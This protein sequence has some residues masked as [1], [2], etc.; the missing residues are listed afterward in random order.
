MEDFFNNGAFDSKISSVIDSTLGMRSRLYGYQYSEIIRSLMSVYFCGG[1][2]IEGMTFYIRDN[3]CG[4]LY[5]DIFALRGW[6]KEELGGI[7]FELNSI[8]RM[9]LDNTDNLWS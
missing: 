6:K 2:C 3:R 4:S 7:E 1:T 5:D 8:P 9:A